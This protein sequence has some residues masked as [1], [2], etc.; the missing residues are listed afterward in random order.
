MLKRELILF[1]VLGLWGIQWNVFA[2][3]TVNINTADAETLVERL[4]GI[5]KRQADRIVRSRPFRSVDDLR[6]F[7]ICQTWI[8]ENRHLMTVGETEYVSEPEYV[9]EP[10][11]VSEPG[12]VNINTA[13]AET[14]VRGLAI[15]DRQADRIVQYRMENGRFESVDDLYQVL[16]IHKSWLNRNRHLITVG[17]VDV[18]VMPTHGLVNINTADV[19]TLVR[20]L[21]IANKQ[22]DEI[23][24]YRMKNGRFESV[25]DLYQV[26][27]IHKS[28]LNRNR[29]LITVGEYV[30]DYPRKFKPVKPTSVPTPTIELVNI[31]TADAETLDARLNDTDNEKAGRIV[32][33]RMRDGF[34]KSVGD[35]YRVPGIS[36]SWLNRNRH[37]ITMGKYESK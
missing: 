20:K 17:F 27:G 33:S 10:E 26:L 13:D 31:N 1:L 11:Y 24:R 29:H 19:P 5:D 25:D 14:L 18:G 30:R 28:W 35:L 7:G 4:A 37:L 22:A 6:L 2:D 15:D 16:G 9:D 3:E 8:D 12:L 32:R 23:V 21:A 34:F 36:E